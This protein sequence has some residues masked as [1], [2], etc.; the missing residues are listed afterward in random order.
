LPKRVLRQD[1]YTR[2]DQGPHHPSYHQ[3]IRLLSNP[4]SQKPDHDRIDTNWKGTH[5]SSRGCH[6]NHILNISIEANIYQF[7]KLNQ[8]PF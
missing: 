3:E 1:G 8:F 4:S 5:L 2:P 6:H 7:G